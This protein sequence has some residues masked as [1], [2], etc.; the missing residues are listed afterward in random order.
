MTTSLIT[1]T[2][3]GLGL[4]TALCLARAG[5]RVYATMRNLERATELRDAA[6]AESLSIEL[7]QL[8]VTDADSIAAGVKTVIEREGALDVLVNNAGLGGATPLEE[9][10]EAEH[11][12]MFEAN[13]WG[14]IRLIQAALPGMRERRSGT[15]VN[16]TSVTGRFAVP[17]QIPYAASKHALEAASEALAHEVRGHG[18]RVV[19]IEPG[20]FATKIWENSAEATRY[21]KTS[22]Y[23]HI[24]R[25]NG[26][27]YAKLLAQAGAPEQVAQAILD[28]IRAERPQLRH[29]VG[30]DAERLIAGRA[31]I[32]DEE[33]VAMGEN[34][35]DDDY[36]ARFK[37][38]FGIEL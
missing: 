32:D 23:K 37:R 26:K 11:R 33:W 7:L 9:V 15:I 6:A 35:P 17:G 16:V 20:I 8:D 22:P 13:Y 36:N 27:L 34:L 24:M 2:S 28:A 31:S 38:H 30:E 19:I 29:V 5:Q 3:S 10:P 1:G 12:A 25:R 18:I 21:D 14:P 4:A